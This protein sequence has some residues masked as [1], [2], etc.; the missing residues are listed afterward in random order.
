ML[1]HDVASVLQLCSWMLQ[2]LLFFFV[3]SVICKN[4]KMTYNVSSGIL[5][6]YS[7]SVVVSL[8]VG[9]LW[10]V[11][12]G[13]VHCHAGSNCYC[14]QRKGFTAKLHLGQFEIIYMMMILSIKRNCPRSVELCSCI[15]CYRVCTRYCRLQTFWGS[16]WW[17]LCSRRATFTDRVCVL[18]SKVSTHW[19]HNA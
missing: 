9:F 1:R 15:S 6:L 16:I 7:L 13:I 14:F 5:S 18:A 4:H 19:R 12:S 11:L 3:F 2:L 8:V 17:L 10:A